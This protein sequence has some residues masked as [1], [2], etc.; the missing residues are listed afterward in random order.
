MPVVQY[1]YTTLKKKIDASQ[2]VGNF[3]IERPLALAES[4]M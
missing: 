1:F 4:E 3:A 2:V